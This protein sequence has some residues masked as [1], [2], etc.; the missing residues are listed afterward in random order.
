[1]W[2]GRGKKTLVGDYRKAQHC[3]D[4]VAGGGKNSGNG[5]VKILH[6]K[7]LTAA[8]KTIFLGS[9]VFLPTSKIKYYLKVQL[10]CTHQY[11]ITGEHT[12]PSLVMPGLLKKRFKLVDSE[13]KLKMNEI[14]IPK[15]T[16]TGGSFFLHLCH[17]HMPPFFSCVISWR[18]D[19]CS[20][21]VLRSRELTLAS[22]PIWLS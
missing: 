8:S 22:F 4:W 10:M 20:C 14:W 7:I 15:L 1:M 21:F 5:D 13:L 19:G 17:Y 16:L 9:E 12:H 6:S 11:K 3:W 18:W 2:R